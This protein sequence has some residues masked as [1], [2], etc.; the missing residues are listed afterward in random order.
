MPRS[1]AVAKKQSSGALSSIQEEMQKEL[2]DMQNRI[3][4]AGA[5]NTISIA[6]KVFK[7]PDG[8]QY[9]GP[10]KAV[11]VDFITKRF[12]YDQPY[13]EDNVAPP[14][15]FAIGSKPNELKPSPNSPEV[16]AAS[17]AE[18]PNNVFGSAGKGKACKEYRVLAVLPENATEEMPL[19]F[20]KVS[21]GA[22]KNFDN[23][24]A[25]AK[26]RFN[27]APVGV[28]ASIDFDK[29]KTYPQL[30]FTAVGLNEYLPAHWGRRDEA[31]T[32]LAAEPN[33]TPQSEKPAPRSR[34]RRR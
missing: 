15:C 8:A 4:S 14:T 17:C 33:I 2:Q 6:G 11:V 21:P 27:V 18:C 7:T 24:V 3:G 10:M 25:L 9:E 26:T 29:S 13:E 1:T 12:L 31:R 20:L 5:S 30:T 32:L 19:M 28:V 34:T 16:Q 22:L 23:F